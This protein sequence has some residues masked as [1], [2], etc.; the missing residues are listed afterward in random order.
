[1]E[2]SVIP[3]PPGCYSMEGEGW[4]L[5]SS[6][7]HPA[8]TAGGGGV[9]TSVLPRPPGCYSMKGYGWRLETMLSDEH[10]VKGRVINFVFSKPSAHRTLSV[11]VQET[12]PS[13]VR[14]SVH[15]VVH[16]AEYPPRKT[17]SELLYTAVSLY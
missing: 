10:N 6:P 11:L 4:R 13:V 3:R 2:T 17:A 12:G 7:D 15:C 14:C 1:M 16:P 5:A 9:E 8:V